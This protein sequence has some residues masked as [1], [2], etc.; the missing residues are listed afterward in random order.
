MQSI[1]N[2]WRTRLI[3]SSKSSQMS[4]ALF[5]GL[6]G[7][8][9]TPR[10]DGNF[11]LRPSRKSPR[12]ALCSGLIPRSAPLGHTHAPSVVVPHCRTTGRFTNCRSPG[13]RHGSQN[14]SIGTRIIIVIPKS[15]RIDNELEPAS[16]HTDHHRRPDSQ[17]QSVIVR[18]GSADAGFRATS[19]PT[20]D[21]RL[22]NSGYRASCLFIRSSES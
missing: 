22:C 12:T 8:S 7:M 16:P 1:S 2:P 14:V 19:L 15:E 17:N 6:C 3:V 20:S 13:D 9:I 18:R 11:K 4:S 5:R 21:I 10:P